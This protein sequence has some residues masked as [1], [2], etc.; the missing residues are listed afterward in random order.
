MIHCII[1][2]ASILQLDLHSLSKNLLSI[3][4][5]CKDENGKRAVDGRTGGSRDCMSSAVVSHVWEFGPPSGLP[6]SPGHH[7]QGTESIAGKAGTFG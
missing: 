2:T 5:I 4:K 7:H 1:D 3:F 6:P